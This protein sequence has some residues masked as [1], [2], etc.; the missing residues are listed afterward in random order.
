MMEGAV[1]ELR[2]LV[3]THPACRVLGVSSATLYRHRHPQRPK[4]PRLRVTP[5]RA[6][7]GA[8]RDAV[9][10][11][12]HSE[13]FVDSSPAAVWATLLDEGHYLA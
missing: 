2:P 6:L 5:P 13:R 3:G 4:T 9:L 7:S 1:Q 10:S 11:E 8:E 12:L